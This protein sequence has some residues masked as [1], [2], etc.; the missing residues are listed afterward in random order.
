[1]VGDREQEVPI[2]HVAL[3]KPGKIVTYKFATGLESRQSWVA[4][5]PRL[6]DSRLRGAL[7]RAPSALPLSEP[8][9]RMLDF[10]AALSVVELPPRS[11][12]WRD[13]I[14]VAFQLYAQ[15]GRLAWDNADGIPIP[16]RRAREYARAHLS[17]P[18]T[19]GALAQPA[20]VRPEYL[21]RLFRRHLRTT[22][23]AYVWE[24]RTQQG[25]W[26]LLR[27]RQPV[28]EVAARLGFSDAFHFAKRIKKETGLWP[29]ELRQRTPEGSRPRALVANPA[30]R[31]K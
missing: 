28:R 6:L 4:A 15:E 12:I 22:P 25:V 2:G 14:V 8:Q 7:Q 31:G 16:V 26:H 19:L 27:T 18:L 13:A 17:D 3:L 10:L 29:T 5:G 30:K 24:Q 21:V 23:M 11:R 9:A 1:V 20:H